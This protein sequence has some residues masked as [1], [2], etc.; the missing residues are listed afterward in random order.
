MSRHRKSNKKKYVY[1]LFF[2][3][4]G[5]T[6]S[7]IRLVTKAP[8]VHSALALDSSLKRIY[9]FNIKFNL[10]QLNP[11]IKNGFFQE[12]IIDYPGNLPYWLYRIKVTKSQYFKIKYLI[13]LFKN[14]PS[15]T[16][17]NI[18][19]A[20]GF[21]FPELWEKELQQRMYS[22]TCSEFIAYMI[23]ISRIAEFNKPLYT[24]APV[25][26]LNLKQLKLINSGLIEELKKQ[27]TIRH[28]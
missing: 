5:L 11:N 10:T 20:L 14:N 1:V 12:S 8:Y 16:S 22:F 23:Q 2:G 13:D 26:I 19:G 3:G 27:T 15:I 4:N 7:I 6:S 18:P 28:T 17:Y 9:S 24:I 25:D 21:L